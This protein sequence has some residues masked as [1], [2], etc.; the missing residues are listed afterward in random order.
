MNT[1][2]FD[3]FLQT[4]GISNNQRSQILANYIQAV[5]SELGSSSDLSE[6]TLRRFADY[7]LDMCENHKGL[8][9]KI[10]QDY[11]ISIFEKILKRKS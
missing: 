5:R 6:A 7:I 4:V 3:N 10:Y 11:I 1:A 9:K 2:R 8:D